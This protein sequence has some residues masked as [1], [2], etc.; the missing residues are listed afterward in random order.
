MSVDDALVFFMTL[1]M[2]AS[3]FPAGRTVPLT[4]LHGVYFVK[5]LT[6]AEASDRNLTLVLGEDGT[7]MLETEFV[8]HGKIV[9]RGRWNAEK[10][11]ADITWTELDGKAINLRMIFELRGNVLVYVGP[12]PTAFGAMSITLSRMAPVA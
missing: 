7:A 4:P 1:R 8:G 11:R 3:D 12:D 5:G 2:S 9:E 6:A 10:T